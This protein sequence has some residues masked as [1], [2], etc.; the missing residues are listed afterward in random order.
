MTVDSPA[1]APSSSQPAAS[2]RGI[3]SRLQVVDVAAEQEPVEQG[4]QGLVLG[5]VVRGR[6]Q[7][8]QRQPV[9]LGPAA[10]DPL[11]EDRE[12][13]VQDRAVGVE[14]LVEEDELGLGEHPGGDRGDGPLA[15]P[16]QV[17]RAEHLVR[18]GEP[19]QQVL[20]VPALHGRG[21]LPDQGRLGR[22]RRPVQEQVLAGDDRQ[23][24]QVDHLVA[25]DE[26]PLEHVDHLAA[27]PA[28]RLFNHHPLPSVP[29]AAA[30]PRPSPG[31][32]ARRIPAPAPRAARPAGRPAKRSA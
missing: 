20:E 25:A 16:H 12:Q 7:R 1:A 21:E 24:D 5:Q 32:P 15:E 6:E 29:G 9:D 26:P 19:R 10:I 2:S 23:G 3:A 8:E 27:E 14:Q 4:P 18:L 13:V 30:P 28:D 11:V 17:D 31:A 22:P